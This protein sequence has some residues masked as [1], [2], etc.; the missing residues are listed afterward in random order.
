[1][2]FRLSAFGC[3]LSD[4]GF[5]LFHITTSPH[6]HF[7]TQ[8]M[9]FGGDDWLTLFAQHLAPPKQSKRNR[10]TTTSPFHHFTTSPLHHITHFATSPFHSCV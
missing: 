6:P 4:A 8:K 2:I 10:S 9:P 7:T 5:R 3:P 1:V